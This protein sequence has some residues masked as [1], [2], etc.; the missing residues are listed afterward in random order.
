MILKLAGILTVKG[1][2]NAVVEYFGPGAETI[3]CTGKGTI[4][5]MGA[6]IGATTSIFPF[7]ESMARYLR[8]T[9]RAELADLAE[10]KTP[11]CCGRT[12]R[13]LADPERYYDRVDRDRPV[14]TLEPHLV[15]PHTPDLAR[16]R[17]PGS[18]ADVAVRGGV[19]GRH[20]I[21]RR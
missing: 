15:G 10:R 20:L 12:T 4:T 7:D 13:S 16:T 19:P 11:T 2:T 9:R 8:A 18:R 17:S 1:G 14:E 3:S 5:N 6:E 21:R